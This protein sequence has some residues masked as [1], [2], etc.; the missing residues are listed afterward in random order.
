MRDDAVELGEAEGHAERV[1]QR[2]AGEPGAGAAR[3]HRHLE[4]VA[5]RQHRGDLRLGLGQGDDQRLLAV[6]GEAVAFVGHG[7]LALPEQRVRRQRRAPS[8]ATTSAWRRERSAAAGAAAAR[9]AASGAAA[10]IGAA[11][12]RVEADALASVLA[13][14]RR[15]LAAFGRA[16]ALPAPAAAPSAAAPAAVAAF[17]GALA[18]ALKPAA[19]LS[20][21]CLSM[22]PA[23][24]LAASVALSFIAV[25]AS[26]ANW[27]VSAPHHCIGSTTPPGAGPVLRRSGGAAFFAAAGSGLRAPPPRRL[28][29]QRFAQVAHLHVH[30]LQGRQRH[31]LH[32]ERLD[33]RRQHARVLLEPELDGAQLVDALLELG[34]I[35]RR[36]DPLADAR[37]RR[38][39]VLDQALQEVEARNESCVKLLASAIVCLLGASSLFARRLSPAARPAASAGR[40]TRAEAVSARSRP[41][42]PG[43]RAGAAGPA[44]RFGPIMCRLPTAA[45]TRVPLRVQGVDRRRQLRVAV[46]EQALHRRALGRRCRRSCTSSRSGRARRGRLR[47]RPWRCG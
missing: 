33:R 46:V 13:A 27:L 1:R 3:H 16:I 15:F 41:A 17:T 43:S 26:W 38:A 19:A 14:G 44:A 45:N 25:V 7:V 21:D 2:A 22:L 47:S 18:A 12:W 23:S 34:R 5:D 36:R 42:R 35:E 11:G 8:A 30:R 29:L 20:N 6:G 32:L 10:F 31:P 28:E 9:T 24:V 4:P 37:H 40:E 39:G